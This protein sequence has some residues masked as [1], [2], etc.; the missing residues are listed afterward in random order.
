MAKTA[1][2]ASLAGSYVAQVSTGVVAN[3]TVQSNG[4]ITAGASACKLSGKLSTHTLPGALKL[5]LTTTGCG[6]LPASSA[7]KMVSKYFTHPCGMGAASPA[8]QRF[9]IWHES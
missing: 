7:E 5:S 9:K 6:S 3:F 4:D 8:D 1:D 2:V